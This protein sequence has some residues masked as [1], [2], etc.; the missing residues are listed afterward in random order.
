MLCVGTSGTDSSIPEFP[1]LTFV[2]S[3]ASFIPSST[4]PHLTARCFILIDCLRRY[5]SRRNNL[6]ERD[7]RTARGEAAAVQHCASSC[8]N[9]WPLLSLCSAFLEKLTVPQLVKKCS[10]FFFFANFVLISI[11]IRTPPLFRILSQ[12]NP[13]LRLSTCILI[14]SCDLNII[15]TSGLFRSA[16]LTK[17]LCAFLFYS[18]RATCPAHL[19]VLIF[20]VRMIF[21]GGTNHKAPQH[22]I[23]SYLLLRI[24]SAAQIPPPA[25][26]SRTSL[27]SVPPPPYK[28]TGK[29]RVPYISV[30]IFLDSRLEGRTALGIASVYLLS[31]SSCSQHSIYF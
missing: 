22:V 11:F 19:V 14:L 20:I 30:F 18:V 25:P 2:H 16:F 29:I 12:K 8:L 3:F 7:G 15:L 26:Y 31:F 10:D 6:P 24:P 23:F 27:A 1:S 21:V 28:G 17:T 13:L 5:L 9:A 4:A